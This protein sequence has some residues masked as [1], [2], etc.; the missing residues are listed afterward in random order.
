[1]EVSKQVI[2]LPTF[3][4]EFGYVHAIFEGFMKPDQFKEKCEHSLALIKKHKIS[5][6][7]V[8]T[9]GFKVMPKE[10]KTF[11]EQDWFPRAIDCGLKKLAHI[12]PDNIFGQISVQAANRGNEEDGPVDIKYFKSEGEA[13]TWLTE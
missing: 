7:L 6:V 12:V 3:N 11:I 8:D 9:S 5:S 13:K 10:N 1:M 4:Q 2:E